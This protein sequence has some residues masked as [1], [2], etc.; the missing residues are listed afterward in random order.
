MQ[1][2]GLGDGLA[3][4]DAEQ[5]PGA[6]PAFIGFDVLGAAALD[7]LLFDA[8]ELDRQRLDDLVHD[9]VLCGEDVVQLAVEAVGPQMAAALGVD[10]LGGDAHAVAGLADRAFQHE[11][12]AEL[13]ADLLHLHRPALVGEGGIARDHEQRL[14]LGEIG[15]QVLGDAVAEILLLGVAAHVGEGQDGDRGLGRHGGRGRARRA[16][17]PADAEHADRP[18]DVLDRPLTQILELDAE[19]VAYRIAHRARHED[20]AGLRQPLQSG[21]DVDAVAEDVLAFDDDVAQ[22]DTDA[23]LDARLVGRAAVAVGHAGLDGDGAA[24][25]LDGAGEVDQ[26][27]IAGALD[28]AAAVG[29]DMRLDQLAE[30]ALQALQRA[31]LVAAH[32]P[33]VAGDIGR[34]NG[35]EPAFGALLLVHDPISGGATITSRPLLREMVAQARACAHRCPL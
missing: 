8:A 3:R 25:R 9:L 10:Q 23:E 16:V 11:A 19:L 6:Q 1:R 21:G 28:D 12:H 24:N 29:R 7:V 18:G 17:G 27:A 20:G 33:A 32:Q 2:L 22:V 30:V 34:Q 31:F 26:Q 14:D 5:L 35:G 15:D 4:A 13:A